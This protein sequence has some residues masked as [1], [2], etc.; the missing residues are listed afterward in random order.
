[1]TVEPDFELAIIGANRAGI[2]VALDAFAAGVEKLAIIDS[3]P[4]VT[5]PDLGGTPQLHLGIRVESI[6]EDGP[7]TLRGE[8]FELT[9]TAAVVAARTH[10][11]SV[12]PDYDIPDTLTDRI[13][14]R[15]PDSLAPEDDVLVIGTG[16]TAAESA[17]DLV[18]S[19]HSSVA[20]SLPSVAFDQLAHTTRDELLRLESA[21]EV[22][23]FWHSHPTSV[24]DADG[25]PMV[26]FSDR[27]TPDLIFD[28]VVYNTGTGDPAKH[29]QR[30]GIEVDAV[31]K[32]AP[33]YVLT[34]EDPGPDKPE[35]DE[36]VFVSPGH[37]WGV[38]HD[39]HFTD[40][41]ALPDLKARPP[42]VIAGLA[43]HLRDKHYNATI[44]SFENHHSDLWILRVKP[45]VGDASHSPGQYATLALGYWEPRLDGSDEQLDEAKTE[46]LVR[47]SYSISHPML[48]DDDNVVAPEDIDGVE[49]YIVLV[50]P[51]EGM[52]HLPEL[53]P[54]MAL[55]KAGDRIFMGGK[56]SGRYTLK[57]VIDPDMD[58]VFL[59]TGTG[60]A[61]HN[62]MT[63]QL[64]R[65]GHTGKIVNACTVRYE[66]D[67]AYLETHRR[68][69]KLYPNYRYFAL[70]TREAD[71]INNKV[72]IQD[73]I[74]NGMLDEVLGHEPTHE[75]SQFFLCG[76]PLMIG[77]PEWADDKPTFP[78][79]LGVCQIL[80]EKGFTIDHRGVDGNVHY[81]E[82]W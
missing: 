63:A 32:P 25:F 44:T 65:D 49:F 75:K 69:E 56:V 27:R 74:T 80:H 6:H 14:F 40:L 61:P 21:R 2:S 52:D 34:E 66:R 19:G 46:K 43:D 60:E 20:L 7:V 36:M 82:Y 76:N 17:E 24:I 33:L 15:L 67:L 11:E 26:S 62:N 77:I 57:P 64:L 53:T 78:E 8:G 3:N 58:V 41:A 12:G 5:L 71:T 10:V 42:L 39:R 50:R 79:T 48:D 1:M 22:A 59:S 35:A 30:L 81:E 70:T 73:M 18:T 72:Y 31:S 45:D 51:E 16:E 55:K 9:A 68:L 29:L 37:A 23:I 28:H 54:R 4:D 13:H 38:I 47:R